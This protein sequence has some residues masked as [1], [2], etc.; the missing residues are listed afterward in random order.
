MSS[1]HASRRLARLIGPSLIVITATEM[2]NSHIW[3]G[4]TAAGVYQNGCVLFVAGLTIAQ[5]HNVWVAR[6][7][8]VITLLGWGGMA[9]GLLRMAAPDRVLDAV[10]R[11]TD[12]QVFGPASAVLLL[13][14]CLTWKGYS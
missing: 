9:L 11:D 7:P 12:R 10:K 4:N 5:N 8:T 13:G 2:L 3:A 14:M 6:W 1:D